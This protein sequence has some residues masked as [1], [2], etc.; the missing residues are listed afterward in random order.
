MWGSQV[1][2][3]GKVGHPDSRGDGMAR[4]ARRSPVHH[5]VVHLGPDGERLVDVVQRRVQVEDGLA[6]GIDVV[7][8]RMKNGG[9]YSRIGVWVGRSQ[10]WRYGHWEWHGNGAGDIHFHFEVGVEGVHDSSL[11]G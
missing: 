6:H 2:G 8:G 5:G 11:F 3:I 10:C 9:P 1:S 4:G 7:I